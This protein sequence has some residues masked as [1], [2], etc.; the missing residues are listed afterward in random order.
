MGISFFMIGN[1]S[2]IILLKIFSFPL[3]WESVLSSIPIILRFLS[4]YCVLEFP[5][6]LS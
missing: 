3:S 5:D 6:I 2:S 4:S 1:I